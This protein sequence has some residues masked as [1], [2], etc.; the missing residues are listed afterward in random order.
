MHLEPARERRVRGLVAVAGEDAAPAERVHDQRRRQVAA[1]GMD[2]EPGAAVHLRRLELG[3]VLVVQQ[4]AQP[5]V[6]ERRERERQRPRRGAVRRVDHQPVE[7]LLHRAL[8]PERPN[9]L[10]RGGAG[11]RLAFADLVPVHDQDARAAQLAGNRE[12]RE[13]RSADQDVVLAAQRGAVCTALCAPPWHGD[14]GYM[15]LPCPVRG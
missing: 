3:V 5:R 14:R 11:G 6:V 13:A 4:L 2:G 15:P 8:Q 12:P 10:G 9:P 7:G 1:I